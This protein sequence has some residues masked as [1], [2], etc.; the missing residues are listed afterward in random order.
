MLDA[1]FNHIG[2]TSYQFQDAWEKREQSQYYDWFHFEGDSYLNFSPNMPKLNT[3]NPEVVD[4]L[5][6][7]AQ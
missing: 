7:V 4:Y 1:V 2:R 3:G 5:L 6:R